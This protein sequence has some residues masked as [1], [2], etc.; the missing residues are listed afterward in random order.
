M[1]TTVF[2]SGRRGWGAVEITTW[3]LAPPYRRQTSLSKPKITV[4]RSGEI[5]ERKKRN[6]L[7]SLTAGSSRKETTNQPLVPE[8]N[9]WEP[10]AGLQYCVSAEPDPNPS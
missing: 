6:P 4:T 1:G 3:P 9:G 10:D 7:K 2:L 5:K 8:E